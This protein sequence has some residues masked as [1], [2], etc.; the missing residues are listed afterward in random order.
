MKTLPL[1]PFLGLNNRRPDFNLRVDKVGDFV[2]QAINVDVTDTGNFVRRKATELVQAMSAP[3]SLYKSY[4]VRA[5]ALYSVTLPTY[6]ETMVT[7]LNSNAKLSWCEINGD[8][9]FSNGTDSGRITNGVLYPWALPTP[10]SPNVATIGGSLYA[11]WYQVTVCYRNATTGEEGGVGPSSNYEL[12]NTGGLRVTLPGATSGATHVDVYVSTVN[13]AIPMRQT[14]VAVGTAT[15]DIVSLVAGRE[16][17]QRY[18]APLPAGTR[19]FEFNGCLCSVVGKRLYIGLPGRAGYYLPVYPHPLFSANISTA[20]GNQAGMYVAADKT[21]FF[22]GTD[23][24]QIEAVRDVLPYGAVSGTEFVI[25]DKE[26]VVVG[27]FGA[28]GFV[29]ADSQGQVTAATSDNVDVVAPA[30]GCSTVLETRGY[31]RVVS[32]GYTM[33]LANKAVTTYTGWDF[34]ST[35][36]GYGTLADGVYKLEGSGPV[37][38]WF[39]DF[40]KIDFGVEEKKHLPAVYLNCSSEE[41]L[42]LRVTLPDG[43]YYDYPARSYSAGLEMHRV[44]PGK[45]LRENWFGLSVLNENGCDFTLAG[46]SFAPTVSTRRI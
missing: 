23:P 13:G 36:G 14:T 8:L 33:N 6:S 19:I 28:K 1:G 41:A 35:S 38:N 21:Y 34:T 46:S 44:D 37:A 31:R 10:A 7:I 25:P 17:A 15:V 3:H 5:S 4:L 40:G 42:V 11:G 16:A 26:N 18:E 29:L 20:I 24:A 43:A 45:G 2:R 27:W 22:A 39:I 12:T 32:C 30:S 9:F